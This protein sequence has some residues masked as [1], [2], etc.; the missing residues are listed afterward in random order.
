[1][2]IDNIKSNIS[3]NFIALMGYVGFLFLFYFIFFN[4][5]MGTLFKKIPFISIE[6]ACNYLTISVYIFFILLPLSIIEFFA[7]GLKK[8]QIKRNI[9]VKYLSFV[10]NLFFVSGLIIAI[11]A[12]LV[13]LFMWW[14][15]VY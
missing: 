13:Y 5:L 12:V 1:M 2:K 11:L 14:L 15:L 7:F 8:S 4:P 9:Y 6:T 3:L 10:P